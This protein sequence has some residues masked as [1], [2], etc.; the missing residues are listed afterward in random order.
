MTDCLFCKMVG[1]DIPVNKVY[2]DDDVL[3]FHDIHP[4]APMHVLV[5]PKRH[6]ASL[7]DARAEDRP[8]LGIL[9]DQTRLVAE[10]IGLAERGYRTIINVGQDGG[11]EVFHLH[12]HILGGKYLPF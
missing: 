6:L 5:I 8:M 1:G 4:K 10:K 2:E 12:I 3:A 11:Q 9:M 7:A